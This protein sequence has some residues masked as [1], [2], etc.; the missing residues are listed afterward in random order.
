MFKKTRFF[1]LYGLILLTSLYLFLVGCLA[2]YNVILMSREPASL[3]IYYEPSESYLVDYQVEGNTIVFRYSLHFKNLHV[4]DLTVS[5][6][7]LFFEESD[8]EGW[9]ECNSDGFLGRLDGETDELLIKAEEE[10]DAIYTFSGVYLGGTVNQQ[11]APETLQYL[12][13]KLTDT[14][15]DGIL[16]SFPYGRE[17]IKSLKCNLGAAS[18]TILNATHMLLR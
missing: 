5:S 10:I 9:M 2:F 16:R 1:L 6:V 15:T 13:N 11:L 18:I 7:N 3:G 14:T 12:E 4:S 8:L 17:Y